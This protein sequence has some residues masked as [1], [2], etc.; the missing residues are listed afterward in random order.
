MNPAGGAITTAQGR[1]VKANF[2]PGS[3]LSTTPNS[4]FPASFESRG[5]TVNE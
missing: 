3:A 4:L 5:E 1:S 2:G